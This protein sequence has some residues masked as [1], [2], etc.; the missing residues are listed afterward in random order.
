MKTIEKKLYKTPDIQVITIELH[1]M[2]CNSRL[3]PD[4]EN[5][6]SVQVQNEDEVWHD[7]FSARGGSVWDDDE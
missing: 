2:L 4:G 3:E 7:M 1:Q 6:I 5:N